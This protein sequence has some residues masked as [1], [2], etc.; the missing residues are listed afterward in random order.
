[1]NILAIYDEKVTACEFYR[2]IYPLQ[3]MQR[4]NVSLNKPYNIYMM[5]AQTM[6]QRIGRGIDDFKGADLILFNRITIKEGQ[7]SAWTTEILGAQARGTA[8]GCD[9]DD[10]LTNEHR[11][12]TDGVLPDPRMWDFV[13]VST[14]KL[15]ERF[16]GWNK[17]I[18]V[19]PNAIDPKALNA[20]PEGRPFRRRLFGRTIGLTGSETHQEDWKPAVKALLNLLPDVPDVTL[21]VSGFMPA[22]LRGH[23]QVATPGLIYHEGDIPLLADGLRVPITHYGQILKD[24]DVGLC[25][26]DPDDSFNHYKSNLKAIELMLSK[27]SVIVT[28]EGKDRVMD[29]GAAVIATGGKLPIYKDAVNVFS[30]L[31]IDN[32]HDSREWEIAIRGMLNAAPVFQVAGHT[33]AQAWTIDKHVRHRIDVY[34]QAIG[35]ARK[36][37]HHPPPV[38]IE[39]LDSQ[40]KKW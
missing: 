31:C 8:I 38:R 7:R 14:D 27:R 4:L 36:H 3:A 6:A 40:R 21:F 28:C 35:R 19:L 30:G 5:T 11:R 22:D 18:Y 15:K 25:P 9:Y 13:T 29:G 17:Y 2:V 16:N 34:Q 33:Y 24:I 1:M 23:P 10:D 39:Y 20:D 12:V 37:A 26:V 32:H